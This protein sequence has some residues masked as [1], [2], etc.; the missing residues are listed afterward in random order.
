MSYAFVLLVHTD[1]SSLVPIVTVSDK[2][3]I[4]DPERFEKVRWMPVDCKKKAP[5]IDNV[6]TMQ[7]FCT[8][9]V[10]L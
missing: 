5:K 1:E 2:R 6:Y 8:L 9:A 4:T 10:S 3:M 7:E